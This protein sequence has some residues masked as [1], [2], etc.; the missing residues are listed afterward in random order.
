MAGGP[1]KLHLIGSGLL[2][3]FVGQTK[4]KVLRHVN[5]N[6]VCLCSKGEGMDVEGVFYRFEG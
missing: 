3:Y 5:L 6:L 1:I 2:A 4:P